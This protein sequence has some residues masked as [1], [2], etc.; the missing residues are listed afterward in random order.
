[1]TTEKLIAQLK[2]N[3]E[4]I[5]T[6]LQSL[7]NADVRDKPD[8]NSWSILEVINHLAD[9]EREDFREHLD[10]ILHRPEEPWAPIDPQGWVT[11]RQYNSRDFVSSVNDFLQERE[12]SLEWLAQLDAPNWDAIMKT[13][14]GHIS[15]GDMMASWIAH[16]LLHL[17]QL[18]ELKWFTTRTILEP[19][20]VDY[21]GGWKKNE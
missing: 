11:Q 13:P 3:A 15:A 4:I 7:Q 5:R 2:N 21:A 20:S 8:E 18:V 17:R 12:R 1:M 10:Q 16:D 14:W 9:E 6:L 19:Y